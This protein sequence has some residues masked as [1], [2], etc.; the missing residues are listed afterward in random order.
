MMIKNIRASIK[1]MPIYNE[2]MEVSFSTMSR[3]FDSV[4]EDGQAQK[5][6]WSKEKGDFWQYN[7]MS[8]K[9]AFW[10]GYFTTKPEI[11]SEIKGYSDFVHSAT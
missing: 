11:K 10:T 4:Y 1:T 5:I 9:A 2:R 3:F 7:H 8:K 6:S